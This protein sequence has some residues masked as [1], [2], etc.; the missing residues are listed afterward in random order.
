MIYESV[1]LPV[2]IAGVPNSNP[3]EKPLDASL[4]QDRK[5]EYQADEGIQPFDCWMSLKIA[6]W[7]D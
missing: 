3:L 7:T 5:S 2:R 1:F 6:G 4:L